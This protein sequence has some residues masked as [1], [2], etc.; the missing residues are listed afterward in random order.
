MIN[1]EGHMKPF[2]KI[3]PVAWIN[4]NSSS[5][6][7]SVKEI[8][9]R[10]NGIYDKFEPPMSGTYTGRDIEKAYSW[11]G[12]WMVSP[13]EREWVIQRFEELLKDKDYK[14]QYFGEGEFERIRERHKTLSL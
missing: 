5:L 2:L 9:K 10:I 7:K 13:E 14:S 3:E 11:R 8:E 6:A 1:S 12:H 4:H